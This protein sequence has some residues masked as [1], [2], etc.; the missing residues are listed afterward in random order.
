MEVAGKPKLRLRALEP[1]DLECLYNIENDVELWDVGATNVPYSRLVLSAYIAN[2]TA[3]IYTDKQVRLVMDDGEGSVVG[4]LDIFNFDPRHSRAEIGVVVAKP[5][6]HLGYA[7][8][9]LTQAI[10]YSRKI[11][12]L[13]QLYAVVDSQN[14]LSI[15]LFKKVGFKH[16]ANLENWLHVDNSFR[17]AMLLQFF[18]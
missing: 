8:V 17:D 12:H 13:N 16:T 14:L 4:L 1:E 5:Y 10:G 15:Q 18:L 6:R 7:E 9:A 11:C 2:S 3:D